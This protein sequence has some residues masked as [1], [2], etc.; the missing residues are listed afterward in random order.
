MA[1]DAI[2]RALREILERARPV[3]GDD[4]TVRSIQIADY[5]ED[6][7]D[8]DGAPVGTGVS[9]C[10]YRVEGRV[11]NDV[12]R[13]RR[14]LDGT[15]FRPSLAV[16]LHY[17]LSIW[18]QEADRQAGLLGWAMRVLADHAVLRGDFLNNFLAG[19]FQPEESV[20]LICDSPPV[21]EFN[22]II[23]AIKPNVQLS[24]PYIVRHVELDSAI[25]QSTGEAV[26]TRIGD[27]A[28]VRP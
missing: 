27:Y 19:A 5:R 25:P 11:G 15:R 12:S 22:N 20:E 13:N 23:E 16:E 24:V 7:E 21:G 28:V 10:L 3:D 4:I 14:G 8:G 9:W 1:S 6:G 17:L 18:A 2:S 26:Q